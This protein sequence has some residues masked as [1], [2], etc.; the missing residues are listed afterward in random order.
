MQNV[1][2]VYLD[3]NIIIRGSAS[4]ENQG[5]IELSKKGKIKL[6]VSLKVTMERRERSSR[7]QDRIEKLLRQEKALGKEIFQKLFI[8]ASN[9][10]ERLKNIEKEEV[11][12][13]M[14]VRPENV[15]S[16]FT[17]LTSVGLL[18]PKFIELLDIKNE[19][20]LLGELLDCH[21]IS[22]PDAFHLMEAHS[23][24]MDYF[25][26]WDRKLINKSRQVAWLK[27]KVMTPSDFMKNI[28][29]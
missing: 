16:T 15:K 27:P 28:L 3:T 29:L 4:K 12:F 13:W 1:I 19:R 10:K 11:K 7:Q 5:L 22:N 8:E 20:T 18:G 23:A 21:K 17:G 24:E 2:T 14:Q 26:T 25:L 6:L 9:E